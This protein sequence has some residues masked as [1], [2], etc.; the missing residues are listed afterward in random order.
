MSESKTRRSAWLKRKRRVG[1]RLHGTA[2]KPRLTVFR[3]HRSIYA[4]LV[5]DDE[6]RTLAMA[7]PVKAGDCELPEGLGGKRAAAYRVGHAVA[8]LAKAK[9]VSKVVFDRNGYLYHGRVAALAQG[10][11]DGGLE[12]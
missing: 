5:D 6:G 7:N 11:R 12:F 9:G 2:E 4:Q 10:A 8:E 1:K 3:S